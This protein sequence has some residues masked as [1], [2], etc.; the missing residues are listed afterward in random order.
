MS[1]GSTL[2]F[3]ALGTKRHPTG[4]LTLEKGVPVRLLKKPRLAEAGFTRPLVLTPV[5]SC[6]IV[7]TWWVVCESSCQNVSWRDLLEQQR[8]ERRVW[9]LCLY[10]CGHVVV[11]AIAWQPCKM[12][13]RRCVVEIKV[14]AKMGVIWARVQEVGRSE[15]GSSHCPSHTL[16]ASF[17]NW[18]CGWWDQIAKWCLIVICKWK[19]P[20][21]MNQYVIVSHWIKQNDL[22]LSGREFQKGN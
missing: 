8:P 2:C 3:G 15:W 21:L 16:I 5:S 12:Q 19:M 11:T 7:L 4:Q 10:V 13:S 17:P 14:K 6:V 18:L 1:A 20:I 9:V 22:I